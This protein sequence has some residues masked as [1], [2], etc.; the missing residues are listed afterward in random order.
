MAVRNN[1]LIPVAI[2]DNATNRE[3][4]RA[5][6]GKAK[7]RRGVPCNHDCLADGW[8]IL[9]LPQPWRSRS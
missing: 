9:E 2:L 6:I 7:G 4:A 1:A 3:T 8:V 5:V